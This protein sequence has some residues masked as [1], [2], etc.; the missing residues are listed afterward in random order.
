ML[1][2]T[3]QGGGDIQRP[4]DVEG[5]SKDH[6]QPRRCKQPE[7]REKKQL[8]ACALAQLL[9]RGQDTVQGRVEITGG[10]SKHSLLGMGEGEER[11]KRWRDY[12]WQ[13]C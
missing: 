7:V 5:R 4:E 12:F 10:F 13:A 9:Q 8:E 3:G 6:K 11:E 2:I 1:G